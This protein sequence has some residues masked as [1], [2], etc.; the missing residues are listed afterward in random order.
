MH[1]RLPTAISRRRFLSTVL[2]AAAACLSQPA[3]A[4]DDV[5]PSKPITIVVAYPPGGQGDVFARLIGQRLTATLKQ[6][7]IVDNKPGATGAIG[8]RF[9]ATA[10]GDG[11]TLLLGQPGEIAINGLVVQK[12]GYHPAKDLRP[13]VM[14]GESPLVMVAPATSPYNTLQDFLKD[15]KARPGTLSYASSGNAT[16]GHLAAAALGLA[17]KT[18]M[19]HVPY[20]G[21]GQAMTDVLGSQ[22]NMFFA[23]A[24]GAAP[25]IKGGKV[26]PLAVSGL[27][28][29]PSLPNVPT[30]AEV[31]PDFNYT[32]W[33]GLFAPAGTPD[34]IVQ[35]LNKEVNRI[36]AEPEVKARLE[37]DG[38]IVR[39]NTVAEFSAYVNQE[40]TKYASVVKALG[41]KPE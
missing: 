3:L 29:I 31:V 10:K 36:L 11:Y 18:E 23:G 15:A 19:L 4:A 17:T 8:T 26:K 21:G 12:L 28:R 22:V 25:H 9:V 38:V 41:I 32:L 27:K 16:P 35:T 33:G 2:T 6:S 39:S 30:V 1:P 7:V 20:K 14:I 13:V 5:Y 40:M 24:P 37:S 34:A